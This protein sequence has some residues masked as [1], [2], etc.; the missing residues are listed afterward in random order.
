MGIL[1]VGYYRDGVVT[2]CH[3][4]AAGDVSVCGRERGGKRVEFLGAEF[5]ESHS[6][7]VEC[8]T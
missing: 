4:L 8:P 7:M 5:M 2:C 3:S 6:T 1:G